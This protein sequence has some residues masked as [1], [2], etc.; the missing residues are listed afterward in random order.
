[1]S[2]PLQPEREEPAQP[3]PPVPQKPPWLIRHWAYVRGGLQLTEL[4]AD[5]HQGLYLAAQ[6]LVVLGDLAVVM[7]RGRADR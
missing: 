6:T 4:L 7:F 5:K 1:M 2:Q 3:E